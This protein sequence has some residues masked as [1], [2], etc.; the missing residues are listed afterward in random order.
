MVLL[1]LVGTVAAGVNGLP[2]HTPAL[3]VLLLI[4][5]AAEVILI[6][7]ALRG[8]AAAVDTRRPQ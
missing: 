2:V 8:R 3:A 1:I 5:S 7:A 4:V 6:R